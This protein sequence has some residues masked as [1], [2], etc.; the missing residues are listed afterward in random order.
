MC[1]LN[2]LNDEEYRLL[3]KAVPSPLI[4]K[5]FQNNPKEFAK[6]K[7]GFR[8]SSIKSKDIEKILRENRNRRFISS[9]LHKIVDDWLEEICNAA[10]S[11]EN[12]VSSE[13]ISYLYVLP[14]SFFSDNI[15]AFFKLMDINV[16]EENIG[17]FCQIVT[18]LKLKNEDIE[19]KENELKT[20]QEKFR[21]IE[22]Q[23]NKE[24]QG[25]RETKEKD[26]LISQLIKVQKKQEDCIS[27]LNDEK[28]EMSQ[29]IK[30]NENLISHLQ[31][32]QKK[33]RES[34]HK[35]EEEI[36]ANL[37]LIKEKDDFISQLEEKINIL[38][39]EKN[40]LEDSIRRQIKD[41]EEKVSL[42]IKYNNPVA[43]KD[44]SE[45]RDYFKY[46]IESLDLNTRETEIK[47]LFC[48]YIV[49][50]F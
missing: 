7:R 21:M 36:N 31:D 30:E 13:L 45:F 16:S 44:L 12:E 1:D 29:T 22:T 20:F 35:A 2:L 4:I 28:R 23:L 5:Y 32:N 41:E 25:V 15:S 50:I 19:K 9:F 42:S 11:C 47:E 27:V 24:K 49:N 43:P 40:S 39:D 18:L 10:K 48:N 17:I 8:P 26:E 46:N 6:I 3:C 33:H 38:N 37:R 14:K 34:I